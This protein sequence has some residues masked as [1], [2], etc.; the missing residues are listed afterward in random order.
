MLAELLNIPNSPEEQTRWSFAHQDQHIKIIN[1]IFNKYGRN[2]PTYIL[3]PMPGFDSK[4]IGTWAYT[5]QQA[6][7]SFDAVLNLG[8]SDFTGVDFTK[9]DQVASWLRLH[10][11]DHYEAQ[12]SLGYSD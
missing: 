10:F 11:N 12:A 8:G 1:A 3:D 6:H 9:Q 7:S 5:H 2:L 4:S